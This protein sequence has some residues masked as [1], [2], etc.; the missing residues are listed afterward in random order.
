M[1]LARGSAAGAAEREF[2]VDV[3]GW[4]GVGVEFAG[5]GETKPLEHF[6]MFVVGWVG[7]D[8]FVSSRLSGPRHG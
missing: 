7:E 3:F 5:V 6:F 2:V 8:L 1:R 4:D